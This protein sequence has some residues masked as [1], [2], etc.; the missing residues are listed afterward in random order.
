MQ[1]SK[2]VDRIEFLFR[3]LNVHATSRE[4]SNDPVE[5]I[6]AAR[7]FRMKFES[8]LLPDKRAEV[9]LSAFFFFRQITS[10]PGLHCHA[11][12]ALRVCIAIEC[13][14]QD[15]LLAIG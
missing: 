4:D 12:R 5:R 14:S 3:R 8:G 10:A 2:D 15:A 11:E 9:D 6:S 7:Q 13:T 1:A